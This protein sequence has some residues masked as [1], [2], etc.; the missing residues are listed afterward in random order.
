MRASN[1]IIALLHSNGANLFKKDV[2][3]LY[4]YKKMKIKIF[5]VS[6][7][8]YDNNESILNSIQ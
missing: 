7:L 1:G 5:I 3:L 6:E 2:F 4:K 8:R